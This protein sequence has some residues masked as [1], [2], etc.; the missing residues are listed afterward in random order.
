MC[1]Q[2]AE[3]ANETGNWAASYH[4]ARQYESQEEVRQAVRFYTR[5]Q[6][7]NNAIRLCKVGRAVGSMGETAC[8]WMGALCGWAWCALSPRRVG[9]WAP[10]PHP[11]PASA[12][13][14]TLPDACTS[15]L[16][17]TRLG[18][19]VYEALSCPRCLLVPSWTNRPAHGCGLMCGSVGSCGAFCIHN[20]VLTQGVV[21]GKIQNVENRHSR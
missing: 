5:A 20:D 11:Q 17:S 4:V 8:R 1:F 2:A 6:A 21:S 10:S 3:I 13:R 9:L 16:P 18:L 14:L 7:F 15:C 19:P 12:T